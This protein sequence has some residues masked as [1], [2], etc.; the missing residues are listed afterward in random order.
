M[1][2]IF[3][4]AK[5]EL[6]AYFTTPLGYIV[7]A[8]VLLLDGLLFNWWVL[9]RGPQLST[10]VLQDFFM[11]ASGLTMV[12]SIPLSMRLIAGD[13]GSGAFVLLET[14]PIREIEVVLG[15]YLSAW[16]FLSLINATTIYIPMLIL[17]NGKISMG[18]VASGYLG[19]LLLGGASLAIGLF[20]STLTRHQ[21][22]AFV[23]SAMLLVFMIICWYGARVSEAPLDSLFEYA[24]LH[25]KHFK[26]FQQG[27]LG[28]SHVVYYGS[29]IFF[30]LLASTKVLE[31]RRWR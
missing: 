1:R 10:L 14:S 17:V 16:L 23:I 9:G 13:R 11:I 22:I 24:A 31:A 5:R 15:K 4:I 8:T 25:N 27:I 19:L 6:G 7:A 21:I 12:A 3:L 29:V 30:F 2:N 18:H 20:G 28:L 26:P